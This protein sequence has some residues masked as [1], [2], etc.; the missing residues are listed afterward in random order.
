VTTLNHRFLRGKEKGRPRIGLT[1]EH[2]WLGLPVFV[3]IWKSFVFPVPLLDFWWHLKAG[4]IIVT[5]K[6]IPQT[7]LFSFTAQ[8]KT[9]ILGNWLAEIA[10]YFTYRLGGLPLLILANTILLAGAV[11]FLL[12]LCWES[13]GRVRLSAIAGII[14]ACCFPVSLRSQVFSFLFMSACYWVLCGYPLRRR[15]LIWCLPLLMVVWVNLHGAFILGL[16]LIGG[17]FCLEAAQAFACCSSMPKRDLWVLALVLILCGL[18]T[19]AN[20]VSYRVYSYIDAVMSDPSSQNLVVEWQPPRIDAAKGWVLFYGLFYLLLVALI[21]A[22]RRPD[23]KDLGLFLCFSFLGL[24]ASRNGV[25]F[26]I[27]ATPIL[28]RYLAAMDARSILGFLTKTDSKGPAEKWFRQRPSS[29]ARAPLYGLNLLIACSALAIL[30]LVSPWIRPSVYKTSL[31]DP[32]T[33]VKAMDYIEHNRLVGNILHPQS[34]GDYLIW[35]LWPQQHSFFD[36][37]V[38]LFGE[39]FVK[40]YNRIFTDSQWEELLKPYKIR[41]M[42]L[43][44][45]GNQDS[46]QKLIDAA[47]S[48]S[49]W[50]LRY[51]DALSIL[52]EARDRL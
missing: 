3:I 4:E 16:A 10:Y 23:L 8:G 40:H 52:F 50:V 14:A 17:F 42:L 21:L 37:R 35:R 13:S 15:K 9:F 43:S 39:P 6:S 44:K 32:R 41:F 30:A 20:P 27:I 28:A 12:R 5:T 25:W 1:I 38:H 29:A 2:L 34:Y 45:D 18:A 33:P 19:L 31:L 26:A 49:H 11:A 47:R 51:E 7:D 24:K 48:S 36:G 22:R 46:S